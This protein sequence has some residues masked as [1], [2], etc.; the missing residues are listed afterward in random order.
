MNTMHSK[1]FRPTKPGQAS[2]AVSRPKSP[3]SD[4]NRI[5]RRSVALHRAVAERIRQNPALMDKARE[6]LEKYLDQYLRENRTLPKAL[7]EWWDILTNQSLETV[8]AFLVSSDEPAFRLRQ[9]SPFAGILEPR[10]RWKIYEAYRPGTY[11][12]SRRQHHPRR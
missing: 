2:A 3:I 5:E 4:H 11:Y 1:N 9:S 6:N 12:S 8:L 7:S 10:E